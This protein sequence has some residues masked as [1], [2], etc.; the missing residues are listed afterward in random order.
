MP[1][2]YHIAADAW[3]SMR[4]LDFELQEFVLDELDELCVDAGSSGLVGNS[5][6]AIY[7][8]V[9]GAMY[10]L[11]LFL[12]ANPPHGLLTLTGVET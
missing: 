8:V 9:N 1:W 10:P 2:D 12:I 11:R 6:H 3:A 4:N 7:P 5:V